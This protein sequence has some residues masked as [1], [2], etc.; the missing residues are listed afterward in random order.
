MM[1]RSTRTYSI[2]EVSA[3]AY[4]EIRAALAAAGYDHAFQHDGDK[5]EVI[6]MA[7]IALRRKPE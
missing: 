2:L 3:E 4:A 5:I 7:G 1:I 6:D